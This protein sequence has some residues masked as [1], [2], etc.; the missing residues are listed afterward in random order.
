MHFE[1][2]K[3]LVFE[4]YPEV[5]I[6]WR[7]AQSI[8]CSA[9]WLTLDLVFPFPLETE[10]EK[11]AV[12]PLIAGRALQ[13]PLAF[14][15]PKRSQSKSEV[16]SIQ[17]ARCISSEQHSLEQ[18]SQIFEFNGIPFPTFHWDRIAIARLSE[19]DSAYDALAAFTHIRHKIFLEI[20]LQR[21][22]QLMRALSHV[23]MNRLKTILVHI[24]NQSYYVTSH[25]V[26][27]LSAGDHSPAL[28][29]FD[30]HLDSYI[31][32]ENGHQVFIAKALSAFGVTP[33]DS[34]VHWSVRA[35]MDLLAWCAENN[36]FA[37]ANCI[38]LFEMASYA[39]SD[40]VAT[41]LEGIGYSQAAKPLLTHFE[42]N[43]RQQH[44][45]IGLDLAQQ[46][47]SL[48]FSDVVTGAGCAEL[49][50]HLFAQTNLHFRQLMETT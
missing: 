20:E 24:L 40:P 18:F 23:S 4:F 29:R 6:A 1:H 36:R 48:D 31:R 32:E 41:L 34:E 47:G 27:S 46:L 8:S 50:C 42:I 38:G 12:M 13:Y 7:D 22:D 25:C 30:Q 14:A 15:T 17:Q 33:L 43:K 26:T 11:G 49:L 9:P 2:S 16:T 5:K 10:E 28:S 44:A 45:C 19:R 35:A 39:D 21:S 3:D 37:L